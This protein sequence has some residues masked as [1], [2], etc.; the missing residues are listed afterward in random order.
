MAVRAQVWSLKKQ[1]GDVAATKVDQKGVD[2][3]IKKLE[4][5]TAKRINA[6]TD[7]VATTKKDLT[8]RACTC[9]SVFDSAAFIDNFSARVEAF[10]GYAVCVGMHS[11]TPCM[12]CAACLGSM[13]NVRVAVLSSFCPFLVA[14]SARSAKRS[15]PL[16]FLFLSVSPCWSF[17]GLAQQN[18][19]GA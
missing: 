8:V 18:V 3:E 1:I 12:P 7:T 16:K 5:T 17:S 13:S 9:M 6:I 2:V 19:G 15:C 4:D 11:N 10:S 14:F